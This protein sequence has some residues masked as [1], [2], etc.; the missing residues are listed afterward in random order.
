MTPVSKLVIIGDRT[1]EEVYEAAKLS[2]QHDFVQMERLYFDPETFHS[3][4]AV[5]LAAEV[6]CVRYCVGIA[7]D[8]LK[9]RVVDACQGV[10]W[11]PITIIHPSAQVAA[12]AT[13][14][15]GVYVGP[16]AV[17]SSHADVGSHCIVHI[18]SSVGH[19]CRIGRYS[20]ILPGARI[21]GNVSLG[22]RTLVG[23]NAF[24]NA[25]IGVGD[26]CRIDALSYLKN[27]LPAGH[28]VS[29]RFPRPIPRID[30]RQEL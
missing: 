23:S 8:K 16:C 27:D 13:L 30:L 28:I 2:L 20:V 1:A 24:L 9:A 3:H 29:P 21:S 19:D 12:T 11:S 10:G 15:E 22:D 5:R 17:I 4:D 26:D 18:H 6:E 7:N 25:G 14:G